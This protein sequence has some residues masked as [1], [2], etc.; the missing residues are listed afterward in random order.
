MVS[1]VKKAIIFLSVFSVV[2]ISAAVILITTLDKRLRSTN[3]AEENMSQAAS[4]ESEE[5]SSLTES[6]E[7][8][9][10][11]SSSVNDKGSSA[12]N[13]SST[14]SEKPPVKEYVAVP[15]IKGMTLDKAKQTLEKVG[16]RLETEIQCSESIADGVVISQAVAVNKKVLKD[17]AVSA[18][19]SAG[20]ANSKG[21]TP[22]NAANRGKVTSQGEWTYYASSKGI[23]R[24]N[25]NSGKTERISKQYGVALNAVGEWLYFA[26]GS[27]GGGI[28]KVKLDGTDETKISSATSYRMYVEN[29]WIYYTDGAWT[30]RIYKMKIDGSSVTKLTE[31]VCNMFLV[32]DNTIYYLRRS[33]NQ[34]CRVST[35]G[36]DNT[37]YG[38]WAYELAL[39]GDRLVMDVPSCYLISVNLDGNDPT[40]FYTG[41]VQRNHFNGY[42]GW[43]YY[44]EQDF[45]QDGHPY[46]FCRIRPDGSERTEIYKINYL[47]LVNTYVDVLDGYI[48]FKCESNGKN[49]VCRVK[50]DGTGFENLG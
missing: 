26:N 44:L 35:S 29:G 40:Y 33:D 1:P 48:Y 31:E 50:F 36:E 28:Y 5:N 41:N 45:T 16:L 2:V 37:E 17:S 21:T 34:V 27:S 39:V 32:N 19:V 47:N 4:L 18:T 14:A 6:N 10:S 13:N 20:K 24:T 23:Y 15:N 30:G 9:V 8:P 11:N 43:L 42:D 38:C 49:E 22:S 12:N 46:A 25:K 7:E 3:A